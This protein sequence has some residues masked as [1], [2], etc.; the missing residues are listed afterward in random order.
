LQ[1]INEKGILK[2]DLEFNQ[3]YLNKAKTALSNFP[4]SME[5]EILEDIIVFVKK[6]NSDFLLKGVKRK[7]KDSATHL[8]LFSSPSSNRTRSVT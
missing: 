1:E 6:G 4:P 2:K 7:I 8:P 3:T 5:K